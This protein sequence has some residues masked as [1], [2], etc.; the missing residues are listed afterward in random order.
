MMDAKR[1]ALM[2]DDKRKRGTQDRARIDVNEDYRAE[3]LGQETMDQVQKMGETARN[4]AE[5]LSERKAPESSKI[6]T[7]PLASGEKTKM[8]RFP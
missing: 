6:A 8:S 7:M 2:P 5:S 1:E 4:S 3:R